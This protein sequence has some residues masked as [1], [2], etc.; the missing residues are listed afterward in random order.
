MSLASEDDEII[1]H[2]LFG[3]KYGVTTTAHVGAESAV[4]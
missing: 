4:P 1:D 2:R 3:R